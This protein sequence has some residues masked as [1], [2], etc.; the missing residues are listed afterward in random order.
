MSALDRLVSLVPPPATP[1][2]ATGDWPAVALPSDYRE[3]VTRYGNGVFNDHVVLLVPF[4]ECTLLGYGVDQLDVDRELRAEFGDEDYPYPLHPEPGGLMVWATTS[5]GARLCW[6]TTGEPDEWQVVAWEPRAS[7]YEPH[8]MGAVALLETWLSGRL[9]TDLLPPVPAGAWFDQPRELKQVYLR[10]TEGQHPYETR[11]TTLRDALS[12]TKDRG[13]VLLDDGTR[14]DHFATETWRV[15]YETAYGHQIRVSYPPEEEPA[16]RKALRHAVNLM[17]CDVRSI[18][19][20]SG[21]PQ[22]TDA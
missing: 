6:L 20:T 7:E 10:L 13:G 8:A 9:E 19:D 2:D 15:T 3:L 14:Q 11:L 16:A 1:V 22:W 4:G 5:N 17:G 18:T 12:P 21:Q